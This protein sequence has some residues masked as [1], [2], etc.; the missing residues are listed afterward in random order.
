MYGL[1]SCMKSDHTREIYGCLR[2][3]MD[4]RREV[5]YRVEVQNRVY[6]RELSALDNE[7]ARLE[8]QLCSDPPTASSSHSS[9]A[10]RKVTLSVHLFVCQFPF[11]FCCLMCQILS[12]A[13][14]KHSYF[15][16]IKYKITCFHIA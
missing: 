8:R 2:L 1:F 9:V 12:V 4:D 3:L 10:S 7:I 5:Y 6:H 15:T 14:R 16:S 13:C 11:Y